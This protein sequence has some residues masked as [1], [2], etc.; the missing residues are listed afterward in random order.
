MAREYKDHEQQQQV[1]PFRSVRHP[2]T[3]DAGRPTM[4]NVIAISLPSRSSLVVVESEFGYDRR[5]VRRQ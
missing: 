4:K 1:A 5:E 3:N 2:T